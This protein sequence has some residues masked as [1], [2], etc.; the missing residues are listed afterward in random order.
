[1]R[2]QPVD[3]A[4]APGEAFGRAVAQQVRANLG[5]ADAARGAFD[6]AGFGQRLDKGELG[7]GLPAVVAVSRA[8]DGGEL[9]E[10][11]LR[12]GGFR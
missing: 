3:P 4:Y 6:A 7:R 9:R 12:G 11:E 1:M 5:P 8:G 10:D 2:R